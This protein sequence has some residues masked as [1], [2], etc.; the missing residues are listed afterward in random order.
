[1]TG[2]AG[3]WLGIAAMALATAATRLAGPAVMRRI[4]QTPRVERFLDGMAAGVLSAI[5]A[6]AA[7]EGGL[8]AGAAV[9]V[10][11]GVMALTGRVAL[12][13]AAGAAAAALWTATIF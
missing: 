11:A 7:A 2:E 8:R 5:V 6:S 1:M 10:A 3:V 4:A 13:M 12:A 9:A